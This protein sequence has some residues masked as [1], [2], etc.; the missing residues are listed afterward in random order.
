MMLIQNR[1]DNTIAYLLDQLIISVS[2][3]K[4]MGMILGHCVYNAQSKLIGIYFKNK[5]IDE[6]GETI[7][8]L[9][10]GSFHLTSIFSKDHFISER[11]ALIK[12]IKQHYCPFVEAK[13]V[14]SAKSFMDVLASV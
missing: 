2:E 4:L 1:Y 3:N 6:Q 8:V 9:K 11:W 13:S 14:W 10:A 5:I 12:R 7:A